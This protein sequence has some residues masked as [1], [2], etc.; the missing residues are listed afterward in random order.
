MTTYSILFILASIGIS[1]TSYLIRSRVQ[2][3]RPA[4]VIGEGSCHFVLESK[5]NRIFGVHNDILGFLFYVFLAVVLG[6]LVI[7]TGQRQVLGLVLEGS[8]YASSLF[9]LFLVYLQKFVIKS[10]CFWCMMSAATN[11]LMA[12]ILL[13]TRLI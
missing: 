1:E 2:N 5:Y 12:T 10:F 7:D 9:S 8:I 3:K 4:C 6:L 13:L 11:F